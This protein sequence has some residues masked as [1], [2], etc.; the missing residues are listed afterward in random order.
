MA[1]I[2][3]TGRINKKDLGIT[4]PHEHLFVDI[5]FIYKSSNDFYK[6]QISSKIT[7]ENLHLLKYNPAFL[8]DNL[9][10]NE[11]NVIKNELIKYRESGGKT[12]V[13]QSSIGAGRSPL[14][15]KRISEET[16]V[17]IVIGTGY[18]VKQTLSKEAINKSEGDLTK[19][20]VY[21]IQNGIQDTKIKPG[22]IGELGVST[23]IEDWDRKLL[24]VAVNSQ[25]ETG[26]PISIHIQ[27][28][29][30]LKSFSE[31]NGLEVLR[32]L[33]KEGAQINKVAI[34]HTDAQINLKYIKNITKSGAHAEFDHFGK[35]F[36]F[37]EADFLM[38]RDID[39]VLALKE[40]ISSGYIRNIL[41][42]QD[43]CMK[44]D[45]IK[46][47]GFGFTHILRNIVPIMIAKGIKKDEID[48]LMMENPKEFLNIEEKF[49]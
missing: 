46:Y 40:L 24:R 18:Y 20:I 4:L 47:G 42:S 22:I 25:K 27:A 10:I 8:R 19:D 11:E 45:L 37:K 26:L 44:T 3:V 17:K 31:P 43:V 29:P 35:D 32:I 33:E 48:I 12:I 21:E 36:Y 16:G 49:L 23:I 1:I 38:D 14:R 2:T 30:T 9:I 7:M 28:V 6:K 15:I 13:E 39:R 5:R 41:I 34:C